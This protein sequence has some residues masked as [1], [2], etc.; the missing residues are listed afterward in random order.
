MPVSGIERVAISII[1]PFQ[2]AFSGSI[3]FVQDVWNTYFMTLLAVKE[4][5]ELKKKLGKALEIRN[6]YEALELENKR[7]KKLVNYSDGVQDVYAAARIV[8][9]DPSPFFK[10]III[11]KG[12]KHSIIK[13]RPVLVPEGIVGQISEVAANY[14]RVLLIIDRN[15]SVD[16]LV[17]NS[18]VRGIVKGNNAEYCSFVY[19]SRKDTIKE[20][21]LIVSSGLDQVFPKGLK[22]GRVLKMKKVHSRLFQDITVQTSVDFDRIEEVLVLINTE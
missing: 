11:D 1:S 7:L 19:A 20:G 9:R 3:Q 14:S 5:M 17:R 16:A 21:E 4:N 18:R 8:G 13:G 15:S 6:R 12:A 2:K 22:I 10:T